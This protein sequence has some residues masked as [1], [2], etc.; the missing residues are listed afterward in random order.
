MYAG[1]INVNQT[2]GRNLFYWLVESAGSPSTDPLVLW[3][4]GGESA[5]AP[6]CPG[7]ASPVLTFHLYAPSLPPLHPPNP[8]SLCSGPGCSGISGGLMS[9]FGPFFPNPDGSLSLVPNAYSWT[10]MANIIYIEQPSGVGNSYSTDTSDY[11]VGD[12]RAAEDV[13]HFLLAFVERYPQYAGRPLYLSGE[14][15]GGHVR[16]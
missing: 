15:Y 11:V 16:A 12:E 2:T 10:Q 9:E 1:Y 3:T 13:Y 5:R 7:A 4:N 6:R 14:S 8:L